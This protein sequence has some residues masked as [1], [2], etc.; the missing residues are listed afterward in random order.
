MTLLRFLSAVRKRFFISI[1][2]DYG[3]YAQSLKS[4]ERNIRQCFQSKSIGGHGDK[5]KT[6]GTED[7]TRIQY[8]IE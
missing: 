8:R 4:N 2:D 6:E 5:K 7:K 1:I 3:I